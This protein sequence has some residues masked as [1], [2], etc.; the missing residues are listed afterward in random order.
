MRR[1]S[2]FFLAVVS[3]LALTSGT[4]YAVGDNTIVSSNPSAGELVSLAPTQLQLQFTQPIG[5]A[6]VIASMGL[7]LTCDGKITNLGPPQLGA[8]DVTVSAALTQT[9]GNGSCTVTWS[10]PDGS[11][12]SYSFTSN[13]QPTSTI[14]NNATPITVATIPGITGS[15]VVVAEPRLGGAIGLLRW[16]SFFFVAAFF[17]GLMFIR[18]LWPEGV[19]YGIAEKYIRQVGIGSAVSLSALAGIT[20]A[21][22]S[23]NGILSSLSPTSWGPIFDTNDGRAL[24]VRI[25]V[26]LALIFFSWIT[27][28]IFEDNKA[29]FVTPLLAILMI[30]YGF[31]RAGGRAIIL[32]IVL[33]IAH[34]TFISMWV[35]GGAIVWRVILHGPGDRDLVD[36]LRGWTR[37]NRILTVG[38]IATG[39][40]QVYRVD[41]I[42]LINSGH[43]RVV[44]LKSLMVAG[45]LF[46]NAGVGMFIRQ[47]LS[48]SNSLNAKAVYRLKRPVGIELFLSVI[49]LALS[50]WLMSMRPPQV[51]LK[52]KAGG[53][54]YALVQDLEGKDNF[55]V[56]LSITPGT[57]G[58]NR[59][60]VEMFGPA[61]IQNFL[62]TFA[63]SNPN[64]SG[65]T[66]YVPL[67]RPGAALLQLEPGMK[68][69]APGSWTATMK[70]VTTVGDIGPLTTTFTITDGSITPTGATTIAPNVTTTAPP[71]G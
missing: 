27:E 39:F 6:T 69:M 67:T 60:L 3:F 8:D 7:V 70:G 53:V 30:S 66:M 38:I 65:Y 33:A 24:F 35:G 54:E 16:I 42:S 48:R 64:F 15:D 55:R 20:S 32:G 47:G 57:V 18:I 52:E 71:V 1:I 46:V 36:A 51:L 44:L 50:S 29:V 14:A 21:Q 2:T 28:Q 61:R 5:G 41:G 40:A 45:L 59:V 63:P 68:F 4:A 31:D 62:I 49:V 34:M 11:T 56:R 23:G 43:G 58:P 22:Y 10:L 9:L 13:T 12:G 17:G 25:L 37:V 26:V 19:E